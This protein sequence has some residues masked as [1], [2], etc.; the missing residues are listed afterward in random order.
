MADDEPRPAPG[1]VERDVLAFVASLGTLTP[2]MRAQAT[3]AERT[4]RLLDGEPSGTAA[5]ALARELRIVLAS[6]EP[7]VAQ[8]V[9]APETVAAREDA[10]QRRQDELAARRANRGA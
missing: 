9:A 5:T 1:P 6:L 8:P 10:V 7:R 2:R 3:V 4:A